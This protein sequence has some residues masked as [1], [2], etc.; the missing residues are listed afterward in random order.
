MI[1]NLLDCCEEMFDSPWCFSR[2]LKRRS[3]ILLTVEFLYYWV[4]SSFSSI[5]C[6]LIVYVNGMILNQNLDLHHLS[7]SERKMLCQFSA[8]SPWKACLQ[9]S[10]SKIFI[11]FIHLK[12]TLKTQNTCIEQSWNL[13]RDKHLDFADYR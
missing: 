10:I 9:S 12:K 4:T 1:N 7:L 11:F 5:A 3:E 13:F 6:I 8:P 2:A